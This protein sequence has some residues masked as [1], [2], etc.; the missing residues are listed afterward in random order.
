[1]GTDSVF[2]SNFPNVSKHFDGDRAGSLC[3][4]AQSKS[5][6]MRVLHFQV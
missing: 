4:V 1:M 5:S 6:Y 2:K 3:A